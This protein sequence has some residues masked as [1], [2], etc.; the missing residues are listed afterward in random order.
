[1]GSSAKKII[2]RSPRY[3][4]SDSDETLLYFA[5]E[6]DNERITPSE[7]IDISATG[8]GMILPLDEAP[9]AGETLKVEFTIPNH[10][11]VAW[12]A[13]VVRVQELEVKK[14]WMKSEE[15]DDLIPKDAFVALHFKDLPEGHRAAI[16]EGLTEKFQELQKAKREKKREEILRFLNEHK[17]KL[18]SFIVFAFLSVMILYFLS[19]PSSTYDPKRGSPWGQRFDF[20]RLNK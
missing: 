13:R 8:V 4:L 9:K 16:F 12:W 17:W 15:S 20:F 1:M 19:Q 18:I 5:R 7:L 3:T 14:W 10:R 11:K 6:V 2:N